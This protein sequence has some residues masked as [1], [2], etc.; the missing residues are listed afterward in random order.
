MTA[1]RQTYDGYEADLEGGG[2]A[3]VSDTDSMGF[4]EIHVNTGT[5]EMYLGS[6]FGTDAAKERVEKLFNISKEAG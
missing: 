3:K 5:V 1:W 4:S 6:S 2:L